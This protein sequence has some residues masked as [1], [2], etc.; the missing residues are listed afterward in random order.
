MHLPAGFCAWYGWRAVRPP[1]PGEA[2]GSAWCLLEACVLIR[3]G[4]YRQHGCYCNGSARYTLVNDLRAWRGAGRFNDRVEYRVNYDVLDTMAPRPY[5]P[6]GGW[7]D[8]TNRE[9]PA[10]VLLAREGEVQCRK[11][12]C[13]MELI[14]YLRRRCANERGASVLTPIHDDVAL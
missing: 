11:R 1:G 4:R 14:A 7:R 8:V 6:V 3:W 9:S 10:F 13:I 5:H 2:D 12:A